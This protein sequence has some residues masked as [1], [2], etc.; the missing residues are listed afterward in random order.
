MQAG[1]DQWVFFLAAL[2]YILHL[3]N[4]SCVQIVHFFFVSIYYYQINSPEYFEIIKVCFD[5]SLIHSSRYATFS[6]KNY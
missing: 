1:P 4:S 3:E 6:I 2:R 5:V